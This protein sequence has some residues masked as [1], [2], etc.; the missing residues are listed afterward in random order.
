MSTKP[1]LTIKRRFNTI[2]LP[3]P[4][5]AP[6]ILSTAAGG[7]RRD[8]ENAIDLR[9]SVDGQP[10]TADVALHAMVGTRDVTAVLQHEQVPV[11]LFARNLET[12]LTGR[13]T[14]PPP[15][16]ASTSQRVSLP[17][18][19]GSSWPVTTVKLVDTRRCVTG[20]PA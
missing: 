18:L 4:D 12:S 17:P 10:V 1:S 14:A 6:A 15:D 3:L 11:S 7:P 8:P 20:M 5:I 9:V 16:C 19:V 2:V 13:P